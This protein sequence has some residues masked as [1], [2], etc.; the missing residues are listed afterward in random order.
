MDGLGLKQQQYGVGGLELYTCLLVSYG[1]RSRVSIA[2]IRLCVIL[3]VCPNYKTKT[4]E[5]KIAKLGI[6][7]VHRDTSPID[8][9]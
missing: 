4:A 8:E 3:S 7:I 5:T 6:Q 1:D 9:H 2:I